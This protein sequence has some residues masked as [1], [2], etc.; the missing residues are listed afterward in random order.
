VDV[1]FAKLSTGRQLYNRTC[2]FFNTFMRLNEY[3]RT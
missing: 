2:D 1:G 3:G